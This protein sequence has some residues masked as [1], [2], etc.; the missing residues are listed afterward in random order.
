MSANEADNFCSKVE[1][2]D[3]CDFVGEA[4]ASGDGVVSPHFMLV[5]GLASHES[6]TTLEW[7]REC[8]SRGGRCPRIDW[9]LLKLLH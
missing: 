2:T 1:W 6:T 9:N 7:T 3:V 5:F 4:S 8:G